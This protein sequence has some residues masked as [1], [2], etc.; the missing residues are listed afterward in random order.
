MSPRPP[1]A[2]WENG[3][4]DEIIVGGGSAGAVLA[5]RLSENPGRRVL[6]V[7]AGS[8]P[9]ADGQDSGLSAPAGQP[10]LAGHNWDYTASI[11]AAPDRRRLF[12]YL[13]G[14]TVGGSSAVNA[15]IALRGFPSDFDG[16]AAAGNH[17]WSWRRVLPYY[18]SIEADADMADQEHGRAGPVPIR[19]PV[20]GELN[21]MATA[22]LRACRELGLPELADLNGVSGAGVG[23]VPLSSAGRRRISTAD[24]HLAAARG[25][26]NLT[27]LADCRATRI[28]LAGGRAAGVEMIA[29]GQL[30]QVAAGQV[31]LT[32][33]A[34]ATPLILQRSGIGDARMLA[35]AGIEPAADL[36]GVGSNLID[37]PAVV[38]WAVP[39]PGICTRDAPW[40]Q[41]MARAG[42]AD[43]RPELNLYLVNN[44]ASAGMPVVGGML[45][46]RLAVSVSAML[47]RPLSRGSVR[48]G[49]PD[50]DASPV[51][52]LSLASEQS[53]VDALMA[54][55]RLAWSV[56]RAAPVAGLLERVL[57]WTDR[58]VASDAM[59]RRAITS[60]VTPTWHPVGTARMGAATDNMSVVDQRCRVHLVDGL[61]VADASVMPAIPSSPPNLTCIMLAE[62]VAEWMA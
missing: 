17:E 56:I 32:A 18:L 36:P 62:R 10:V 15:G 23:L 28:L 30:R 61:R 26:P 4:V 20:P 21:A 57:L 50:P 1:K 60:F 11:G 27:V 25:R 24:T 43:H 40:H 39:L 45:G 29:G 5:S 51:I 19:R 46:G 38:I 59:L 9:A 13:L 16:W 42:G 2:A 44:V 41:V 12:P 54:G 22:F 48:L 55:T 33:G 49:G 6:L 34:V 35:A 7:E 58:L 37:H 8:D 31:T 14:K 53:D 3:N 52:A 47:L